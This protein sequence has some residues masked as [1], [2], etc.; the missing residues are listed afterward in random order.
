MPEFIEQIH[1]R[2]INHKGDGHIETNPTQSRHRSL[3]EC[4]RPLISPDLHCTVGRIPVLGRLQSLHTRFDHIDWCVAK[5]GRSTGHRTESADQQLW[6]RLRGI[7]TFVHFPARFHHIESNGLI[8]ALL[9]NGGRHTFVHARES[10]LLDNSG[11][12]MYEASILWIGTAL[13]VDEF[14]FDRFHW[15]DGQDGLANAGAKTG[16]QFAARRQSAVF[17]G[18]IALE[19][20]ESTESELVNGGDIV[21]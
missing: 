7:V 13:I 19:H 1:E 5:D 4:G 12:A 18:Q 8:R 2:I 16:Q 6:Y 17:I 9:Q 11:D 21:Y 15:S 10:F 14:H 3:I 20:F